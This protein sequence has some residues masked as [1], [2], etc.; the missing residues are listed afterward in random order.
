M[1]IG[2]IRELAKIQQE[3]ALSEI[4]LKE[5]SD[6]V[7]LRC[8]KNVIR[9]METIDSGEKYFTEAGEKSFIHTGERTIA[10]SDEKSFAYSSDNVFE[11]TDNKPSV[12]RNE[13]LASAVAAGEE[14]V[15]TTDF[16]DH[17]I[18]VSAPMVGMFYAAPAPDAPNFVTV[19]QQVKAGEVLCIIEAMKLMNEIVAEEDGI[20]TEALSL[21]GQLVEYGQTLFRMKGIV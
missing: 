3:F 19:G 21:N 15:P 14:Q 2:K 7:R 1:K 8:E 20:I 4:V 6:K 10:Y 12:K 9:D 17:E 5:G 11:N 18:S 16:P 13:N